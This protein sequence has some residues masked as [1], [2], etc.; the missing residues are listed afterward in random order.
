MPSAASH[1]GHGHFRL[2]AR[3]LDVLDE[4]VD[5]V[6]SLSRQIAGVDPKLAE[7]LW[8]LSEQWVS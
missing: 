2:T 8:A 7:R 4:R 3:L 1:L 5:C 6:F